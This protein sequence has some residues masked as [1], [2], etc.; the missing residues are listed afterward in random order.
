[1]TTRH[2]ALSG[3][4]HMSRSNIFSLSALDILFAQM[5]TRLYAVYIARK[6]GLRGGA[7]NLENDCFNILELR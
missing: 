2:V 5:M 1:M 4:C 7:M 3:A 6:D